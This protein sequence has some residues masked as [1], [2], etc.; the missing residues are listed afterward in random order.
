MSAGTGCRN[1]K[2]HPG[3]SLFSVLFFF[4]FAVEDVSIGLPT[5]LP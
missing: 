4:M 1:L 5:L 3:S 2:P